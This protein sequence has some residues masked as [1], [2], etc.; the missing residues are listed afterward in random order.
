M[1][2]FYV[3]LNLIIAV[4][5]TE[6]SGLQDTMIT[7]AILATMCVL[8]SVVFFITG[9]LCRHYCP[10]LKQC[11]KFEAT[12]QQGKTHSTHIN[13]QE[14]VAYVNVLVNN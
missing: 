6:S 11:I 2:S 7:I 4:I 10:K 12:P 1:T 8:C 13:I 9:F 14:N 3:D 5:P